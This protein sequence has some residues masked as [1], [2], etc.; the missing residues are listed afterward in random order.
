MPIADRAG[1]R[2]LVAPGRHGALVEQQEV[3]AER[4]GLDEIHA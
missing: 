3:I 4:V 1:E 2:G